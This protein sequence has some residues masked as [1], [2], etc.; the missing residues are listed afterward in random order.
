M[1]LQREHDEHRQVPRPERTGA[2]Q[3]SNGRGRVAR[4]L[5]VLSLH[6]PYHGRHEPQQLGEI[7]VDV[8]TGDALQV[9]LYGHLN[10][11]TL[12]SYGSNYKVFDSQSKIARGRR[13]EP[14]STLARWCVAHRRVVVITWI[15]LAIA[16]SVI[17]Q[18][19]GRDYSNNF[20]LPGTESQQALNLLQKHFPTQSGD[21]DQIVWH[22]SHGTVQSPAVKGAIEP[23]LVKI[24]H[25][26]YVPGV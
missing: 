15:A 3:G 8:G 16:V 22:T 5:G 25:M 7:G 17:A 19:A 6:R 4:L 13:G 26:P 12:D 18:T 21:L 24:S 9:L 14:I 11:S 20:T 1:P 10:L 23:L 2:Q